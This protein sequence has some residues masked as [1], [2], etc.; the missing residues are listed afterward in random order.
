LKSYRFFL[1]LVIL[2]APLAPARA[3]VGQQRRPSPPAPTT[4]GPQTPASNAPGDLGAAA[5]EDALP[6]AEEQAALLNHQGVLVETLDGRVVR[7]MG[8]DRAFNPASA[9][10]LATA[11]VALRTFG[12]KHR[13]ATT[14]W[15]TGAFDKATGTVNGNLIVSGRDPSF[16]DEHAVSVARELNQLGIKT[17]TGDLVVAPRFTMDFSPST[18]HSGERLYDTLDAA[19]RPAA[20]T[21]AW[22]ES[23]MAL[24]DADALR[25][26]PSVAVMGAVYVDA[27]PKEAR[28]IS[29]YY[30]P[31]LADVLKALLCYS[32]NFMAERLGDMVGGAPG[33]SRFLSEQLGFKPEE[34]RLSTTNGLGTNRLT[35][36]HMMKIYRALLDVLHEEKMTAANILPVAGIDPGTLQKR[37][38]ASPGRG[39]IIAKTGTLP[40]TDGGASALV[41]QML[42]RQGEPLLFVILDQR[43]N[44]SRFRHWQDALVAEIQSERGGPAPFAYTPQA[45][46]IRLSVTEF[47]SAR[48]SNLDEYEPAP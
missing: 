2:L 39:S 29:T 14:I 46:A 28:A 18:Q 37:Y 42:T 33:V 48:A 25:T 15:I 31:E 34:F 3:Q 36:R 35:P 1:A 12:A 24:H 6:K 27:V 44:V 20:A 38:A 40:R 23:R 19:R 30:S 41:G 8:A 43:G 13:F 47:D 7:E 9:V 22:Y 17:V 45:L 5:R 21:R 10:K 4:G 26:T 16:H 32:N 11:L